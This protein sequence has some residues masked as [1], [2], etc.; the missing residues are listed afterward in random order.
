MNRQY[1]LRG[2]AERGRRVAYSN[3]IVHYR[4]CLRVPA[5]PKA[6]TSAGVVVM[7]KG[8]V[9]PGTYRAT[10]LRAAALRHLGRRLRDSVDIGPREPLIGMCFDPALID[11]VDMLNPDIRVFHIYDSYNKMAGAEPGFEDL[12]K[13]IL[14]FDLVTA[15][16]AHMYRDVTGR[17]PE[18]E[19]IVPNGVDFRFM[20]DPSPAPSATAAAIAELPGRKVGY[21]GSINAKVDLELV[22]KLADV[23][24]D[25]SLVLVGPMRTEL[26]SEQ[27]HLRAA[28]DALVASANVHFF[29][30]VP[31][32]ELPAVID[33]LDVGCIFFRTDREDWVKAGYPL[34]LN[35][36]LARGLPV[37]SAPIRVVE[38]DFA[39]V[40]DICRS[41]SEWVDAIA[42][43]ATL[44]SDSSLV[45]RRRRV[46]AEND[47]S[48][49][50]GQL[51]A[52]LE[53]I[54][55]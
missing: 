34:K 7:E 43:H 25:V 50:A 21:V 44:D 45:E 38:D 4:E 39:D 27:P 26:L 1:L 8:Y 20:S 52:L 37:L 30:A 31:R 53:R 6:V 28:Y 55:R 14:E 42:N 12:R 51:D 40:V 33:S 15:S 10:P 41:R 16:S 11:H 22:A 35:E 47:W 18:K 5:L 23:L 46:A 3:G 17:E 13:L 2:L 9:L 24:E 19:V 29:D 32:E 48:F 54:S 36:Y 49:R